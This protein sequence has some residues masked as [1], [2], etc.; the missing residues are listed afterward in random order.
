MTEDREPTASARIAMYA[1]QN[2]DWERAEN[3]L[4][5]ALSRVRRRKAE[6]KKEAKPA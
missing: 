2:G 5:D 4:L 6:S 1:A 3:A